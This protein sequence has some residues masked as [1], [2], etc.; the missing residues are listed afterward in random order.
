MEVRSNVSR[1]GG[2]LP[3]GKGRKDTRGIVALCCRNDFFPSQSIYVGVYTLE[4]Q[5]EAVV[6]DQTHDLPPGPGYGESILSPENIRQR[7]P[8]RGHV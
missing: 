2:P 7:L 8:R 1:V 6:S 3:T 4:R 5:L